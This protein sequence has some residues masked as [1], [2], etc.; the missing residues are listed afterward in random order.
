MSFI[1]NIRGV[2]VNPNYPINNKGKHVKELTQALFIYFGL[3]V[4]YVIVLKYMDQFFGL[5]PHKAF[6]FFSKKNWQ[7]IIVMGVIVVPV[8]EELT[9]RLALKFSPLNLSLSL[10]LLLYLI[11]SILTKSSFYAF[12]SA[13]IIKLCITSVF[14]STAYIFFGRSGITSALSRI[15]QLHYKFIILGFAFIFAS[16]HIRNMEGLST[17]HLLF[18]PLLLF[19]QL[20]L[21]VL[22]S[23]FR[24]AYGL[25]WGII[26][27]SIV[28]AIPILFILAI[29]HF[30]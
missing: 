2:L 8:I 27:H 25:W 13:F 3:M 9:F 23:Y 10:S 22:T 7:T 19:P 5:P 4:L 11:L 14:F 26:L 18:T 17:K 21:V 1:R 12:D 29:K 6:D 30:G 20:L 28:N 24:L 15:W 16:L